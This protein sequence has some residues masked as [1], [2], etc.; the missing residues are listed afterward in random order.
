MQL[1]RQKPAR[2]LPLLT[3]ERFLAE[4]EFATQ[5]A[6]LVHGVVHA[7]YEGGDRLMTGASDRHNKVTVNAIGAL[8]GPSQE[9]GCELYANGMGVLVGAGT[10]YDPDVMATCD[11]SGDSSLSHTKPCLVIEVLSP[12]T[13]SVDERE[14]RIAYIR[15]PTMHD[16]LIVN[17]DDRMV[18][19]HHRE[20]DGVWSWTLR[21]PG[22]VCSTTC[23]G[24]LPVAELFI[25]L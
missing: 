2:A 9:L 1:R 5:K 8:L 12:S 7:M 14:K 17:A 23:L 10:V 11:P 13:R 20:D 18:D 25:G 19:H 24:P 15:I 6:E 16:Y 21:Y 4:R 3:A 22:D